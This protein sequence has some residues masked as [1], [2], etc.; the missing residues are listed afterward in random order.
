MTLGE[1]F[2]DTRSSFELT[3]LLVSWL[4][5]TL[6]LIV[7]SHLHHRIRRLEQAGTP[8]RERPYGHLL[9][10]S[11]RELVGTARLLDMPRVVFFLSSGCSSCGQILREIASP[12]WPV[13]SAIVWTAGAPPDLPALNG[14]PVL[15]D[16]PRISASLGIRVTPFGLVADAHGRVVEAAPIAGLQSLAAMRASSELS[17]TV[18]NAPMKGS[19]D[20]LRH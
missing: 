19:N 5:W 1:A 2:V 8:T 13:P 18:F 12:S 7:A 14:T 10:R 20:E 16:G 11:L 17:E 15:D 6:M 9:G 4:A 3:A